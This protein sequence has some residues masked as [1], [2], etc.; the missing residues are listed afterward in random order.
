[1]YTLAGYVILELLRQGNSSMDNKSL[2]EHINPWL[3]NVLLSALTAIGAYMATQLGDMKNS[4]H[5][6]EQDIGKLSIDTRVFR[7]EFDE[8]AE[9]QEVD[10][11][12]ARLMRLRMRQALDEVRAKNGLPP[13]RLD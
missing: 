10:S 13:V 5:S 7:T 4:L 6:M 12:R 2:A 8:F 1:M 3:L 11:D 9:A